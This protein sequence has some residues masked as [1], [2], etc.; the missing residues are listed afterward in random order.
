M[1]IKKSVNKK[2]VKIVKEVRE[3]CSLLFGNKL[4]DVYLYGSYARGDFDEYSDVDILVTAD[5]TEKQLIKY[6]SIILDIDCKLT[7]KY[8]MMV[9]VI[10]VPLQRFSRFSND[11]PFYRN[12]INEGI[13]YG[14]N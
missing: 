10:L 8:D 4:H 14:L 13:N 12:V 9:S 3:L 1:T 2:A 7:N 6:N 11:L 5:I